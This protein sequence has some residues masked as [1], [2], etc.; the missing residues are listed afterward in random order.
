[1]DVEKFIRDAKRVKGTLKETPNGVVT[2]TGCKIYIPKHYASG[3]LGSV[4]ENINCIGFFA[5]VI[6]DTYYAVNKTCANMTFSPASVNSVT[7]DESPYIEMVFEPGSLAI[8]GRE[9]VVNK[10][11]LF[12]IYDDIVAKGRTPWYMNYSDLGAIF[13]TA[14]KHSGV[15][16]RAPRSILEMMAASRARD[17]RDRSKY[18]RHMLTTQADIEKIKPDIIPLR[19]VAYGATSTTARLLG[20]HLNEGINSS[21]VNPS[22][23]LERVEELL[24]K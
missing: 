12:Q 4:L 3:K 9:L 10:P 23:R 14:L 1:M 17:P 13:D 16:L 22:E 19:S 18:Y 20:A 7:V 21:L 11:Q 8:M 6:E 15:N 2:T 24:L 5:M